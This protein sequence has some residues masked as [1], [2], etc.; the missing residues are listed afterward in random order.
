MAAAAAAA[1]RRGEEDKQLKVLREISSLTHNRRCFECDQRGPTYVNTTIGSF[2]CTTCSGILRGL[3][4]PHRIK[5]ISMTTFTDQEVEFLQKN[6]NEVCRHM[7]MGLYNERSALMPDFKDPQKAKEFLQDKYEKRKWFVPPEQARATA[8]AAAHTSLSGSSASSGSSTP[9]VRPLRAI[10]GRL[11]P[12]PDGLKHTPTQSPAV[13]RPQSHP[14]LQTNKK[15]SHVDLLG[16]LGGDPFAAPSVASANFANFSASAGDLGFGSAKAASSGGTNFASFEAFGAPGAPTGFANFPK[17]NQPVRA[18]STGGTSSSAFPSFAD[19]DNFP[20]SSSA[21]LGAVSA[22]SAAPK[23]SVPPADKYAALAD[24]DSLFSTVTK[25]QEGERTL[26]RPHAHHVGLP[27]SGPPGDKYAGLGVLDGAYGVSGPPPTAS[28]AVH[29]SASVPAPPF[30][31]ATNPFVGVGVSGSPNPFQTNGCPPA[32]AS[33]GCPPAAA[34]AG[35]PAAAASAGYPA[36]ATSAGYPA[37]AGAVHAAACLPC[38]A[39]RHSLWSIRAAQGSCCGPVCAAHL[40]DGQQPLHGWNKRRAV[41]RQRRIHQPLPVVGASG[42]W[43]SE[44]SGIA[45]LPHPDSRA[46]FAATPGNIRKQ[47]HAPSM[48]VADTAPKMLALYERGEGELTYRI[49]ALL[50]LPQ[51]RAALAFAEKRSSLK[52]EH[53]K[54]LVVRRVADVG[55]IQELA[56][57]SIPGHRSMNPCPVL[58]EKKLFLFFIAVPTGLSEGEQLK[59]GRNA[60]RLAYACSTDRGVTWGAA[61]DLTDA[62]LG[63]HVGHWAT[64]AL[65][66]GHGLHLPARTGNCSKFGRILIPAHAYFKDELPKSDCRPH[67]FTIYSDDAGSTWKVG[68]AVGGG[69]NTGECQVAMVSDEAG[70]PVVICNSRTLGHE[71]RV[72]A[73]SDDLGKSFREGTVV[74]RLVEA[75]QDWNGC[76]G[77]IVS[78]LPELK[79]DT[80][81]KHWLLYSHPSKPKKRLDLGVYLNKAP[82]ALENWSDPWVIFKGPSGY[83]DLAGL[84]KT[85]GGGLWFGCLYEGGEKDSRDKINFCIFSLADVEK[86]TGVKPK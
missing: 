86:Y 16:E 81:P 54:H 84:G 19:F 11:T 32:A 52:D 50:Y 83:S 14:Q 51:D 80:M 59:T 21:D 42:V 69:V 77:S 68:D 1:R 43:A 2:V 41:S 25:P 56:A 28:A 5:S 82:M 6:G 9:E 73:I 17:A 24:L 27:T 58:V 78:F 47:K 57:A 29:H 61:V 22:A 49:P 79:G 12:T 18:Q 64:F 55:K 20:K 66:P 35:F 48:A 30:P 75:A 65:G 71:F 36:T 67:S 74:P 72:Q 7:W 53:A 76:H 33:A 45:V 8:V 60:A 38:T 63:P 31:G 44:S 40:C 23:G 3:N 10:A 34:T 70:R 46:T 15:A 37:T 13:G 62:V 4:P 26:G 39:Q 85:E